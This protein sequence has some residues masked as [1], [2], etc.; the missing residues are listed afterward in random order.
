M[1]SPA[2]LVPPP[3]SATPMMRVS[4]ASWDMQPR[5]PYNPNAPRKPPKVLTVPAPNKDSPANSLIVSSPRTDTS[6]SDLLRRHH[7]QTPIK[8]QGIYPLAGGQYQPLQLL[9]SLSDQSL[10]EVIH[11]CVGNNGFFHFLYPSPTWAFDMFRAL[12]HFKKGR[13]WKLKTYG[14]RVSPFP[15]LI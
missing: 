9:D 3:P 8:V 1:K 6:V 10:V 11:R 13:R 5:L 2:L 4:A 14:N 12:N 7:Q 15:L